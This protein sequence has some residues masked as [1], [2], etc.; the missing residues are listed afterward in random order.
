MDCRRPEIVKALLSSYSE[1]GGIN[2]LDTANL[3]SKPEIAKLCVDLLEVIFPGFLEDEV[4][5]RKHLE[6]WAETKIK[7]LM[8]QLQK[9]VERSLAMRQ[10]AA[11]RKELAGVMVCDFLTWLPEVRRLLHTDVQAAYDGDPAA[12]SIDEIIL[13]YPCIEAIAIQRCAHLLYKKGLPLLP[14]IMTE[15]AHSRTGID[16]HPGAEI[17]E[18]FF[19]DHGT[20]VVIGET[21]HIGHH[22]KLY[23]GVTLGARSFQ[24]DG[25]GKAVRGIRRHPTVEDYVTIY[26]NATILGGGTVI[27]SHST[28]GGNVFLM[29]SVPPHSLVA[30]D[31]GRVRILDK[32]RKTKE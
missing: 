5:C 24:K 26:P 6:E 7:N 15:W 29:E 12:Q 3:P 31:E 9:Q 1:F 2:H 22:V 18:A 25:E 4:V 30:Y 13:S 11:N 20:G 17:G 19:I 28:I 16:I 10:E 27:G 8:C 14:R 32:T 21:C 23:H